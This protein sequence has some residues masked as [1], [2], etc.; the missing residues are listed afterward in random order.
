MIHLDSLDLK[1]LRT[2][3]KRGDISQVALAEA[4]GSSPASCWRRLKALEEA[5]V[6]GPVVRLLNPAVLGK[7][8]DVICQVRM[9][10]HSVEARAAFEEFIRS[11]EEVLECLSVSGEWDYQ[12]RLTVSDMAEYE[13][14][15]MNRLLRH[16]S[17]ATSASHFALKRIKFTTEIAL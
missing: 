9:K 7:N 3:Q 6:F 10:E 13:N 14:F 1:I 16:P 4:V 15:L 12:I 8:L 2:L 11:R 5:G 17:V